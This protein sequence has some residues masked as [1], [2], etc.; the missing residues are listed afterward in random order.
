MTDTT[1]DVSTTLFDEPGRH[2]RTGTSTRR[3]V[4]FKLPRS[5]RWPRRQR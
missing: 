4:I 2:G 5:S 3:T 1:F